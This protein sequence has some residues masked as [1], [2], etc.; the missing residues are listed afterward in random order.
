MKSSGLS[1]KKHHLKFDCKRTLLSD[2]QKLEDEID[3]RIAK[4]A[5]LKEEKKKLRKSCPYGC[6]KSWINI[7]SKS[8]KLHV[9]DKCPNREGNEHKLDGFYKRLKST[10]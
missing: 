10:S 7:N 6:G 8:V 5:Q 2:E 9:L 1:V 3:A 4:H